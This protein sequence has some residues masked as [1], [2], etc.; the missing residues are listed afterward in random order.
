MSVQHEGRPALAATTV[1]LDAAIAVTRFGL[2]ARAGEMARAAA[3][4]KGYLKAQIRRSGADQPQGELASSQ[5]L[6]Q[7]LGE[8]KVA[9][10]QAGASQPP[11]QAKAMK[12]A[13]FHGLREDSEVAEV[14]ARA[15]LHATTAAGFRERWTLFWANHFTASAA[16]NVVAILAGAFEREAIRPNVFGRFEDLLLAST[17]H[18]AMLFYLDQDASVGPNSQ[19]AGRGRK[20]LNENLARE[21]MELHTVGVQAGYSQAD[22]TEFARALTGWTSSYRPGRVSAFAFRAEA[23]EPGARTIMGRTYPAGGEEQGRAVLHDLA[24]HP[25]TA[26]HLASQIAGHFV[27]DAP[28]QS[29]V[30]RLERAWRSSDGRLDVVAA[31]LIDAPEAWAPRPAKFKTPYDFMVSSWRALGVM[32]SDGRMVEKQ[33]RGLGQRPMAPPSPKGWPDTATDWASPDQI[34]RRMDWAEDFAAAAPSQASPQ[35]IAAHAMGPLLGSRSGQAIARAESR[36]QAIA[37]LL[38]SPEFQRR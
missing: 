18:P 9:N 24:A 35:E 32:P 31:A 14:L 22:V 23:H 6:L 29:L 25:A 13:A 30:D 21:V 38:M 8:V 19:A 36:P 20:G 34:M 2:G 17:R 3:D 4:P 27:A 26:R 1:D 11:E 5:A 33:A 15:R 28:P 7:R 37:V 10:R 12:K 16:N